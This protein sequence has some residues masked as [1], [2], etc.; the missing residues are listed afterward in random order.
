[1][2]SDQESVVPEALRPKLEVLQRQIDQ[3]TQAATGLITQVLPP[4]I[5]FHFENSAPTDILLPAERAQSIGFIT[6]YEQLPADYTV[7]VVKRQGDFHIQNL[8]FLRHVLND[9]RSLIMNE[10]DSV[11]YQRVH[12]T[13][14]KMLARDDPATGTVIRVLA[15]GD[16]DVTPSY[17][18]WLSQHNQA[19]TLCLKPLEFNY[20]YNGILQHSDPALSKRYLSDYTS[21]E[22]NWIFWKHVLVLSF[23]RDLLYPY[24]R[25]MQVVTFPTLGPL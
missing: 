24:H 17:R 2:S 12:N 10:S 7:D 25:L 21:G 22:V 18:T 19:I 20:L 6:R 11:Y 5:A 23:I 8:G 3:I 4:K 15:E 16:E 9:F 14:Y 13:W 1:M